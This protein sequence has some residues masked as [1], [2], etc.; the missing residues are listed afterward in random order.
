MGVASS[1][2]H[3]AARAILTRHGGD[4]GQGPQGGARVALQHGE[5]E[6]LDLGLQRAQQQPAP[7]PAVPVLTHAMVIELRQAPFSCQDYRMMLL[8][9]PGPRV[10]I[11]YREGLSRPS[12][13]KG[14]G[15]TSPR[16]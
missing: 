4:P 6:A 8:T 7:R 3:H 16:G 13:K 11:E 15:R 2:W 1:A 12:L 10:M 5:D 14:G 9:L